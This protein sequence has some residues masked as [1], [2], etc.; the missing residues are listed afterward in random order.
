MADPT[1][2]EVKAGAGGT[3]RVLVVGDQTIVPLDYEEKTDVNGANFQVRVTL[4]AKMI[5][6][7]NA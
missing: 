4:K 7:L 6:Y 2:V 5:D 1:I 3:G